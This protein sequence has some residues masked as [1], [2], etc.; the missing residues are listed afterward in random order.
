MR[1]GI[2]ATSFALLVSGTGFSSDADAAP[3][4]QI[5]HSFA[6]GEA[7][8]PGSEATLVAGP[9]NLLYGVSQ[10]GGHTDQGIAYSF[11][12]RTGRYQLLHSFSRPDGGT[13]LPQG[14]AVGAAGTIYVTTYQGG[15]FDYGS[16]YL[17][18]PGGLALRIHSF[19]GVHGGL[20]AG[21]LR[22]RG[23]YFYGT[24]YV[25]EIGQ[26]SAYRFDGLGRLEV[27]HDFPN[28]TQPDEALPF[29]LNEGA[30]GTFY[31]ATNGWVAPPESHGAVYSL[32]D[33]GEYAVLHY[34][35]G[36][37]GS[38]PFAAPVLAADG[39]LYGTTYE[40]GASDCGVVYR[41]A[42]DN[43]FVV[44]HSFSS[45]ADGCHPFGGMIAAANGKLYGVNYDGVFYEV[46]TDGTVH[47]LLH[48]NESGDPS[49]VQSALI[50]SA[51]GVFH[52]V[53]GNGGQY[54]LG[55][56]FRLKLN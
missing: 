49:G 25:G 51:P 54:S 38:R 32:R 48:F 36:A 17:L 33:N 45:E 2:F 43:S 39:N 13:V 18:S 47:A 1:Y 14:I 11:N 21:P 26:G 4:V 15:R 52:G 55:T 3:S 37:D 6:P 12:T 41:I 23:Q 35:T 46:N 10:Q 22:K 24:G 16:I 40:G 20:P 28:L 44:V 53:S 50:E 29:G 9:A 42:P 27:L 56:I 8:N 31:G 34:F 5:V 19:D 7:R 30:G